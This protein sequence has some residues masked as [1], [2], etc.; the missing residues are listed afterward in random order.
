MR[1]NEKLS[2]SQDPQIER[3]KIHSPVQ[4]GKGS[5]TWRQEQNL[6]CS[7]EMPWLVEAPFSKGLLA[8]GAKERPCG[9]A[10]FFLVVGSVA[11]TPH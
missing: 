7:L 9:G 8:A 3:G 2:K 4:Q 10:G 6:P 1:L 5:D 11:F